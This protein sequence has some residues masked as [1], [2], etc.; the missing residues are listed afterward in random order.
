MHRKALK[1]DGGSGSQAK[2]AAKGGAMTKAILFIVLILSAAS[3]GPAKAE[4]ILLSCDFVTGRE[5]KNPYTNF[6]IE[7]IDGRVI[8]NEYFNKDVKDFVIG[9]R[10]ITYKHHFYITNRIDEITIDLEGGIYT[11]K[12]YSMDTHELLFVST[13]ECTKAEWP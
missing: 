5:A 1:T 13:A 12:T 2:N 6:N 11:V 4:N 10:H 7:I 9:S 3:I 8:D